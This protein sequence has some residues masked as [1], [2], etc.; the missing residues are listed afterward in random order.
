MKLGRESWIL[1]VLPL[2]VLG[3]VYLAVRPD[4]DSAERVRLTSHGFESDSGTEAPRPAAAA[5]KPAANIAPQSTEALE[6][7]SALDSSAEN[8][9]RTARVV[10][11]DGRVL[12]GVKV[13]IRRFAETTFDGG[14]ALDSTAEE[15][16]SE[17]LFSDAE[18]RIFVQDRAG[19]RFDVLLE[20]EGF[21]RVFLSDGA[22]AGDVTMP[23]PRDFAGRVVDA[24]GRPVA[25]ATVT[26][27]DGPRDPIVVVTDADGRYQ[28]SGA[29][30]GSS[31]VEVRHPNFRVEQVFV[32]SD[33]SPAVD[34]ALSQGATALVVV[35]ENA[36]SAAGATSA[37]TMTPA[38]TEPGGDS[39]AYLYDRWTRSLFA[40]ETVAPGG[41]LRFGGLTQGRDYLL[42]IV[43]AGRGGETVFRGGSAVPNVALTATGSLEIEVLDPAGYALSGAVCL[44]RRQDGLSFDETPAVKTDSAGV[45]AFSGLRSGVAFRVVIY[46]GDFAVAELR[47]LSLSSGQAYRASCKLHAEVACAGKVLSTTGLPVT[48]AAVRITRRDGLFAPPLFAHTDF[49]GSFRVDGVAAGDVLVLVLAPGFATGR[50][51]QS[52]GSGGRDD[53]LFVR[54]PQI[55]AFSNR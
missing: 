14:L 10:G 31:M 29:A 40:T 4:F 23:E 30:S 7:T 19:W 50:E 16:E 13:R 2:T 51:D 45:A 44:L 38:G 22:I 8:R 55:Q 11:F 46:H 17:T 54:P 12:A 34:V 33:A 21:G 37:L 42:S 53:L 6:Q 5:T 3:A 15:S 26:I 25:G 35:G 27:V 49:D 20:T 9:W 47:G 32:R 48:A 36:A 24:D 39:T 28:A 43:G 18:G 41:V 52:I 1:V